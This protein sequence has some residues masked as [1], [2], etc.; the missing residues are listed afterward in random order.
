MGMWNERYSSSGLVTGSGM[1]S[2]MV[3]VKAM[4][5]ERYSSSGSEMVRYSGSKKK[6]GR[7]IL[8]QM[9]TGSVT[10]RKMLKGLVNVTG[11]GRH[12]VMEK[13]QTPV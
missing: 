9:T 3:K 11:S 13:N 1:S 8:K 4:G 10:E 5:N 7:G 2:E 6:T 12:L